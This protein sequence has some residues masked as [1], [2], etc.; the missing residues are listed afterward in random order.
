MK[1]LWEIP[2]LEHLDLGSIFGHMK[3]NWHHNTGHGQDKDHG[4]GHDWWHWDDN[5]CNDTDNDPILDS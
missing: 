4:N 2:F 3:D 5:D 1:K